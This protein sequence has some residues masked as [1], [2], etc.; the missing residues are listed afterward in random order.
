MADRAVLHRGKATQSLAQLLPH[1]DASTIDI[2]LVS[3]LLL[4]MTELFDGSSIGWRLH[5]QG[6]KRLFAA[7]R[8]K[9][10]AGSHVRFLVKLARF[11]DSAATTSTCKP[12]L[13]EKQQDIG[14][15]DFEDSL[16]GEDAAIYGI[17]KELFHLVDRVND[18][19]SK[20]GTRVD[21][22]SENAFRQQASAIREQLDNWALD[23]GGLAGAVASLGLQAGDD[24]LHATT[25]YE[26][27]L[28]LRQHQVTEGYSLADARVS[29]CVERIVEAAQ[30]I[31]YGSPLET[32]LLF[33][34]VMAGGAC[35]RLE[36]R[37]VIHDRLM[38]MEKTCGFGYIH[39]SR[40][41]VER[42]WRRREGAGETRVNWARIR[43]EEMG[44]LAVF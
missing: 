20:R 24:V 23:F 34:L 26:S 33:P 28:R 12:P 14:A 40:E 39:Q 27:A 5:L 42:V 22:A 7:F 2:A 19:A 30:K 36:D 6:A 25:A 4:C 16:P 18:L 3:C 13:I 8:E 1:I 38:V 21:E 15:F 41:L 44:G 9:K 35:E 29:E 11:L 32:C 17:P 10:R 37:I 43:Y 31:R